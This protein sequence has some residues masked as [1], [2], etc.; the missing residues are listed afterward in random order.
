MWKALGFCVLTSASL[1][2]QQVPVATELSGD[3]FAVKNTWF[4]GGAGN[5]DLL[6]LDAAA[7]QLLVAHGSDVQVVDLKSG[8]L[9][10]TIGG[11]RDA[12]DIALDEAGEFAY[13]SD[14]PARAVKVVNRRGLAV[15]SAIPVDC[16]PRSVAYEPLNRLVFA[17]CGVLA[18]TPTG[19]AAV[20]SRPRAGARQR[21]PN[22]GM[23]SN[24]PQGVSEIAVIDTESR[25]LLTKVEIAGD[26]RFAVAD[27][28]GKLYVSVG[29]VNHVYEVNGKA[30]HEYLPPR[31]AVLD[32]TE[33]A[34]EAR[35]G[36]SAQPAG[37]LPLLNWSEG[38]VPD[39]A[40]H[41]LTQGTPCLNPQGLAIDPA[42]MRLFAACDGN[43]L[44]VFNAGTGERVTALTTG[45]GN[46]TIAYDQQRGMIFAANGEGYGS[47]TI[48]QQSAN[49]DS[50]AV[51]QNLATRERARTLALDPST[52]LVYLVTD[53]QGVDLT[54]KGGIGTLETA[55]VA[56]SFQVLVVG[57]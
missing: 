34:A 44:V 52:G 30:T 50:Y 22:E 49:T 10:G 20:L 14:G 24:A 39:S 36:Q 51:V 42:H 37:R 45:P 38:K 57:H 9:V 5:W 53:F 3:P 46:E 56:G 33:I 31:I 11:F 48:I 1:A 17:I 26:F 29:A 47:L 25:G 43:R 55:P 32:A 40:V 8:T 15:E 7:Q 54:K 2:A 41:F 18:V 19:A 21:Q 35:G 6:T 16:A 4:I 23:E 27:G 13:I 28:N 12:H